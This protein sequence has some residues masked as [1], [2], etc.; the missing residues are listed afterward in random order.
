MRSDTD[1]CNTR[2]TFA[3]ALLKVVYDIDVSPE[4][5]A[6]VVAL[7]HAIEG[8][9]QG[10]VLGKFLVEFLPFLRYIP[11]WFPGASSQRLFK[12]WQ[13]D[14]ERMKNMPYERTKLDMVSSRLDHVRRCTG[15][16]PHNH[17]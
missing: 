9:G 8:P 10:L 1:S 14:N 11:T 7:E 15:H 12:R 5:D 16:S 2:S 13:A 3:A 17:I 4:D 6:Y